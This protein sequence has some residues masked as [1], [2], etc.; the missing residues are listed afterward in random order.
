[1]TEEAEPSI[2]AEQPKEIFEEIP[3][4]EELAAEGQ[5]ASL[6]V[7]DPKPQERASE[8]ATAVTTEEM[9]AEAATGNDGKTEGWSSELEQSKITSA[10]LEEVGIMLH[11]LFAQSHES[12]CMCFV[13]SPSVTESLLK[14]LQRGTLCGS[15]NDRD[16]LPKFC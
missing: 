14:P 3:Q 11:D 4:G 9:S 1:M 15:C 12:E 2:Q 7:V 16:A 6:T 10:V 5:D 13:P 8:T